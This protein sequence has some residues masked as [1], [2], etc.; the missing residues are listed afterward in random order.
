MEIQQMFEQLLAGQ[1][2]FERKMAADRMA[3]KEGLLT[4]IKEEREANQGL[5]TE[6]KEDLLTRMENKMDSNQKKAEEDRNADKE[7]RKVYQELMIADQKNMAAKQEDLLARMDE[8][9]ADANAKA[10]KQEEMLAELNAKMDATIKSIRSKAQ[11]TIHNRVENVGAELNQ[12][13]EVN[14][15]KINLG[16]MQPVKEHQDVAREEAAITPVK[17]LR[18]RHRVRKPIAGRR[19][20]PKRLIQG[21]YGSRRKATVAGKRT[22][23]H[24]PVAWL[25]RNLFRRNGT[26]EICG[27][28]KDLTATGIRKIPCAQVVRRKRRSHVGP[29]VKHRTRNNWTRNKFARTRK[30]RMLGTG[31]PM[32]QEGTNATRNRGFKEQLRFG[33]ER[34][35]SWVYRTTIGLKIAKQ[36]V[37]T[38]RGSRRIK[39]WTLWRGRPP[40]KRKEKSCT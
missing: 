32:R 1:A 25:K 17:G 28:R 7:E 35:T 21:Y 9:N 16:M 23:H 14:T 39:Q 18:K 12:K 19:K 5:L 3:D 27:Q 38:S 20:E 4:K 13:T 30:G 33:N 24:A 2:R 15:E 31:Q 40:P 26:P 34:M 36:V 22:Y 11:E 10:A 29:S 37:G 6:M 8:M